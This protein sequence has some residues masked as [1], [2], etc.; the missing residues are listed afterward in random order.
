MCPPLVNWACS[1]TAVTITIKRG[2]I[3]LSK[4]QA[5]RQTKRNR[6]REIDREI[7]RDRETDRERERVCVHVSP[8]YACPTVNIIL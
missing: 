8:R 6:Q 1:S 5:D 7:D 2:H 3:W 4:R